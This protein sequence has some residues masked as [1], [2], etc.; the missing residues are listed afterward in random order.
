MPEE[1]TEKKPFI[2]TGKTVIEYREKLL[3]YVNEESPD[4]SDFICRTYLLDM[5]YFMGLA[6]DEER[7]YGSSG[8]DEFKK[9]LR[10]EIG[11]R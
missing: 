6:I 9:L 7:F 1:K 3:T 8:F 2:I 10:E 4:A 11:D 5:L